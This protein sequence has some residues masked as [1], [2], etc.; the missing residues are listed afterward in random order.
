MTLTFISA[1]YANPDHTAVEA[2]TEEVGAVLLS[3][4]DKPEEWASLKKSKVKISE[5]PEIPAAT[6]LSKEEIIAQ[7]DQLKAQLENMPSE[8]TAT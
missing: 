3:K 8:E 5:Y 2:V 6:P 7:L 1:R 4:A